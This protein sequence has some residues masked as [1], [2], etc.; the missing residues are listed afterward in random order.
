MLVHILTHILMR[1][2]IGTLLLILMLML[3][4]IRNRIRIRHA[5]S[6]I[7]A[8]NRL[9]VARSLARSLTWTVGLARLSLSTAQKAVQL[10]TCTLSDTLIG[11]MH[12]RTHT[13]THAHTHSLTCMM[14]KRLCFTRSLCAGCSPPFGRNVGPIT[15]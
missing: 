4:C 13:R 7:L 12:A 9:S 5:L 14:D 11:R 8:P 15:V 6:L 3:I 2:R 1:I 10:L